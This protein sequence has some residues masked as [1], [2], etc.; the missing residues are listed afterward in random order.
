MYR[1]S[2]TPSLLCLA[3]LL[4]STASGCNYSLAT[5]LSGHSEARRLGANLRIEFN[6]AADASNRAVMADTD[7]ASMASAREAAQAKQALRRDADA[8]AP[9]LRRMDYAQA[10]GLLADFERCYDE[11][12]QLDRTLLQLAVENSNLKAQRLS[13]GPAR[14]AVAELR[15]DLGAVA[16]AAPP[17][18]RERIKALADDATI[19]LLQIEVLRAP[20]IAESDDEKMT[21]MEKDMDALLATA[22][23][24]LTAISPLAA[25]GS[26]TQLARAAAAL[27]R[28]RDL[29]AQIIEL[30]R[31]NSN[32][33]ALALALGPE[34]ALIARCDGTLEAL[35][36][37]L[38]R[39]RPQPTR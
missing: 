30:S 37:A 19:A 31:R 2:P 5:L 29:H 35:G 22:Q 34:R 23:G 27:Q 13:F 10:S 16:H 15:A 9:L 38:T 25:P 20:H 17:K 4:A 12:Q 28:F 18:G 14:A 24:A 7:E 26:Q 3:L 32:V 33:R 1:P 8:L 6:R 39:T 11:Y 36:D 21:A